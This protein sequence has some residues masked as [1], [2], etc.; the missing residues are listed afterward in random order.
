MGSAQSG[1]G[2]SRNLLDAFGGVRQNSKNSVIDL[3][4]VEIEQRAKTDGYRKHTHA[5][6]IQHYLPPTFP[7]HAMISPRDI[8]LISKSWSLVKEGKADGLS[9]GTGGRSGM[10]FFFDE[11]YGRLFQ[12]SR[13]FRDYFGG[14]IKQRGKI[15][16]QI[17]QF[18]SS[19]NLADRMKLDAGINR[20]GKSHAKKKHK[21]MDVLCLR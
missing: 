8:E 9:Y 3:L 19:L 2:S 17:V 13:A 4:T 12:R 6:A 21:A 5:E 15:L 11:F 14:D 1:E 16:L 20:L 10:V 7:L 18:I